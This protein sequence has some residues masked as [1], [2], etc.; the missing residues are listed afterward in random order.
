[1]SVHIDKLTRITAE[2]EQ[3]FLTEAARIINVEPPR[4]AAKPRPLYRA[5]LELIAVDADALA[6]IVAKIPNGPAFDDRTKFVAMAHALGGA[7][8][9]DP[10]RAKGLFLDWCYRWHQGPQQEGEPERVWDSV[11]DDQHQIGADWIIQRAVE[12]KVDV[13]AY[14]VALAQKQFDADTPLQE[15]ENPLLIAEANPAAQIIKKRLVVRQDDLTRSAADLR[16]ILAGA[17]DLFDRGGPARLV[18]SS[19]AD[20]PSVRLLNHHDVVLAAHRHC[21]PVEAGERPAPSRCPSASL[22]STSQWATSSI[23]RRLDGISSAPSLRDDGCN[24]DSGGL[25]S[26]HTSVA[27]PT[28]SAR[29]S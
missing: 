20:Q 23:L 12:A 18:K 6:A 8:L 24:R 17:A 5:E 10:D 14:R 1:M 21:Q 25:R 7:F 9:N 16:D 19:D 15:S 3:V 27:L 11:V 29:R 22:S 2:Q 4:V 28:T 13:R 26:T